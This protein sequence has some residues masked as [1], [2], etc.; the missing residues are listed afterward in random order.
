[1]V[2]FVE[3]L[4]SWQLR[5]TGSPRSPSVK[6]D[7]PASKVTEVNT[8]LAVKRLDCEIGSNIADL[9]RL[10]ERESRIQD[11][12]QEN[13]AVKKTRQD[14]ASKPSAY[15]KSCSHAFPRHSGERSP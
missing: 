10:G 11:H 4:P 6:Q 9:H 8:P 2:G 14:L 3:F 5:A 15:R 7:A 13:K 1:M 12:A